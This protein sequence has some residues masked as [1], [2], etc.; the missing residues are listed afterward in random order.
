MDTKSCGIKN[1]KLLNRKHDHILCEPCYW[2]DT[3]KKM[4]NS[5]KKKTISNKKS[6]IEL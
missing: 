2:D 6:H 3:R 1:C 4:A 5:Q